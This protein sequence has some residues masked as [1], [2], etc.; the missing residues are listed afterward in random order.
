MF[1]E[2]TNKKITKKIKIT[3]FRPG[4]GLSWHIVSMTP[5]KIEHI[6]YGKKI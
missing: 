4:H 6:E 1:N 5:L 3:I 2:E